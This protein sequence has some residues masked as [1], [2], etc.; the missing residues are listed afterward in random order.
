M[1]WLL[2]PRSDAVGGGCMNSQSCVGESNVRRLHS[3][4][5]GGQTHL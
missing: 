2:R 4:V 5:N 3:L 1:R